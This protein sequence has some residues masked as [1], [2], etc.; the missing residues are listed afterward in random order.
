MRGTWVIA[1]LLWLALL[2]GGCDDAAGHGPG[3]SSSVAVPSARHPRAPDARIVPARVFVVP[4]AHPRIQKLFGR[5]RETPCG[6][7]VLRMLDRSPVHYV[8][9]EGDLRGDAAG[10]VMVLR[11]G[12][13][14]E[15]D[16]V[17][18]RLDFHAPAGAGS[19][20]TFAHELGHALDYR[21]GVSR[22]IE[23]T[24]PPNCFRDNGQARQCKDDDPR[25]YIPNEEWAD[26]V[27]RCVTEGTFG[28]G[29]F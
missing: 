3:A 15:P 29:S 10:Q 17:R 19:L 4:P 26:R 13:G 25:D 22:R 2:L 18:I 12:G 1:R 7:V 5:L 11:E 9:D 16:V 21:D 6:R 8:F 14:G 24:G 28:G 20:F 23:H 27:A